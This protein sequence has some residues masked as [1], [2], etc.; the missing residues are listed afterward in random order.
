MELT[1]IEKTILQNTNKQYKYIARCYGGELVLLEKEPK[2]LRERHWISFGESCEFN[3][4]KHLFKDI[5][6]CEFYKFR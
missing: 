1:E 2:H 4:F 6:N 5:K 3:A